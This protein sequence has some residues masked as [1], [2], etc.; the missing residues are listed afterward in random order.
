MHKQKVTKLGL[1]KLYFFH[2]VAKMG[3]IIWP[4]KKTIM[5]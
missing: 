4:Q 5:G 3:S 1:Q 2:K